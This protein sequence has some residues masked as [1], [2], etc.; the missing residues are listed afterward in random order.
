MLEMGGSVMGT[1]SEDIFDWNTV[2]P[3]THEDS[4]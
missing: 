4:K 1:P 3:V 2:E